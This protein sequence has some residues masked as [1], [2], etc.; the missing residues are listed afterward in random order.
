MTLQTLSSGRATTTLLGLNVAARDATTPP[1]AV[2][3]R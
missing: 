2:S 3:R 1:P